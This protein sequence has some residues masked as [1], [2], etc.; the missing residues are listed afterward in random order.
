MT[1]TLLM[2]LIV[3][4]VMRELGLGSGLNSADKDLDL[5]VRRLG[6]WIRDDPVDAHV[7]YCDRG[8]AAVDVVAFVKSQ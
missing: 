2:A 7:D 3:A 8:A 1:Q 5:E 4:A 6:V